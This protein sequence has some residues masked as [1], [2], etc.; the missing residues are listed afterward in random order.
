[1]SKFFD[2]DDPAVQAEMLRVLGPDRSAAY[3]ADCHGVHDRTLKLYVWNAALGASF[4]PA[5]GIVEVSLRNALHRA[6]KGQ[7]G[8]DWYDNPRF[9]AIDPAPFQRAINRAKA[10]I[11]AGGKL[12]TPPR[13]VAQ[14]MFGFW[15]SLLRPTYARSLWPVLRVAF[16]LYTRRRRAADVL[17]PLVVFRNR[18]AHHDT[19]YDRQPRIIFDK[20]TAAAQLLSPEL[21][22]WIDHHSRVAVL[23]AKGPF[24]PPFSFLV[25]S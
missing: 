18:V 2:P 11:L 4:L 1:V 16:A 12:V 22:E 23:L 8:S 7:F 21:N 17:E 24:S 6:L 20:L 25:A 9:I 3:L 15:V 5:I 10:H 13:I 19:I 14:L